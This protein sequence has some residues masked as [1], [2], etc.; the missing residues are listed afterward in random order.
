MGR[1]G[2]PELARSTAS[3]AKKRMQLIASA[4]RSGPG[5]DSLALTLASTIPVRIYGG[6]QRPGQA[7]TALLHCRVA[8]FAQLRHTGGRMANREEQRTGSDAVLF[9][10]GLHPVSA[11]NALAMAA[12][13]G[14]VGALIIL[15]NE[16]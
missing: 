6:P 8:S 12:F 9:R 10:T 11:A 16:L 2:C 3:T 13:I 4:S 7:R 5:D 14:F 15:H 1:P